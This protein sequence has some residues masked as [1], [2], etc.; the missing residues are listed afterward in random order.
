ML[1]LVV[2]CRILKLPEYTADWVRRHEAE[3]LTALH[4]HLQVHSPF[5]PLVGLV[6]DLGAR[7]QYSLADFLHDGAIAEISMPGA[8]VLRQGTHGRRC[9]K[10]PGRSSGVGCVP[11]CFYGILLL[12]L[13]LLP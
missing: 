1:D 13:P 12:V 11:I 2:Y 9:S 4:F 8:Q 7:G 5:M 10:M 3:I 6:A